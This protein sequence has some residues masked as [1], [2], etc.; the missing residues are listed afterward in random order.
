MGISAHTRK[1]PSSL[2]PLKVF[3]AAVVKSANKM[4]QTQKS[5]QEHIVGSENTWTPL[6]S[7]SRRSIK[8]FNNVKAV[9]VL[10]NKNLFPFYS[11]E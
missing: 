9:K 3:F 8:R 7:L 11:S 4:N 1:N 6:A 5:V 2:F 10:Q